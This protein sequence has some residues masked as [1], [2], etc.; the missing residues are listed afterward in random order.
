MHN[1]HGTVTILDV[2]SQNVLSHNPG[3]VLFAG[4][5]LYF[6]RIRRGRAEHL[7]SGHWKKT[8]VVGGRDNVFYFF[9]MTEHSAE[10]AP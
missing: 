8:R 7:T 9:D 5:F 10:S 4:L 6:F 2:P 1:P 3:S